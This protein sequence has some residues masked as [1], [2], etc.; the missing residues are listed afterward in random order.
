MA[1]G[2]YIFLYGMLDRKM[3]IVYLGISI[4]MEI[5]TMFCV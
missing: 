3:F 4:H 5:Q 1:L 2:V